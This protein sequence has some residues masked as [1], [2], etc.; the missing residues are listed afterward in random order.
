MKTWKAELILLLITVIWGATFLFTKIGLNDCSPSLYIIFRFM[1][2]L[3]ISL[4]LFHRN[5]KKINKEIF[6]NG[7]IL[8]LLF[9]GGFILQT[10]GLKYTSVSNSAF[11]TGLSVVLTPFAYF[12]IERKPIAMW[13]K[14]GVAIAGIGLWIFT[15]PDFDNIN[16]G[17]VLTLIS[18]LFWAFYITFMDVFTRGRSSREETSLLVIL[19]FIA[20]SSVAVSGLFLI[21]FGSITLQFTNSLLLSL[22]FN[23][24]I[25]SFFLTFL[26]TT[27]QRYSNPVKAALIF[28]L[29]PVFASIFAIIFLSEQFD[30]LH[31]IGAF[32]LLIGVIISSAIK[33]KEE[34]S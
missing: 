6:R 4:T 19:Q 30:S 3:T 25:A 9:G 14:V 34:K 31:Y 11:I 26:H 22:F 23:G 20:A 15:N 17:D 13:K 27:F 10:F 7:F 12:L 21:D 2:A 18:C 16:L 32:V 24:V 33:D 29:E 1:I 8:G 5:F 28:A